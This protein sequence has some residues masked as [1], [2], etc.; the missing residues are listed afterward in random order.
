MLTSDEAIW[1]HRYMPSRDPES[2]ATVDWHA[3]GPNIARE[4]D[5]IQRVALMEGLQFEDLR[6]LSR[7]FHRRSECLI[8]AV[9]DSPC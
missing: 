3:K 5:Q 6:N 2:R 4:G 1:G 7:R 8:A 9:S